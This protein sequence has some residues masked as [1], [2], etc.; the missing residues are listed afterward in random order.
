MRTYFFLVL[1]VVHLRLAARSSRSYEYELAVHLLE[2][3][4]QKRSACWL[5]PLVRLCAASTYATTHIPRL[6]KVVLR[7][8]VNHSH[9]SSMR[10]LI[11]QLYYLP[12][13]CSS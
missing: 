6:E 9:T 3:E 1:C 10:P 8:L 2:R 5:R 12:L 4:L 7:H 11:F 13:F